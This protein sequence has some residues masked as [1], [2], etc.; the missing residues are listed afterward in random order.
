MLFC[1]V[2][3]RFHS[4]CCLCMYLNS[5]P[6]ILDALILKQGSFSYQTLDTLLNRKS[7][8]GQHS[9]FLFKRIARYTDENRAD[10]AA[11]EG[12]RFVHFPIKEHS[13]KLIIMSWK[14]KKYC[15]QN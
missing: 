11:R 13:A 15:N 9:V 5:I 8:I 7:S 2:F 12:S 3:L 1:V 6:Y 4:I 14:H 10:A